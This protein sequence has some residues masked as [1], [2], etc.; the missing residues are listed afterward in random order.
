MASSSSSSKRHPVYHGIRRRGGKWVSE[1]R[2]P[3][4]TS[5]IWLGTF[6]TPEM[7]ATAYDVA[8]LALKGSEAVLN[9][10]D[11]AGKYPVPATNS[12]ADIRAAATAAAELIR[13]PAEEA[14]HNQSS[15]VTQLDNDGGNNNANSMFSETEFMDE[16][17]IFSM[18]SLLMEMAEGMLLS[19][20]RMSPHN[21]PEYSGGESLWNYF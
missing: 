4:K 18:P 3:R 2:E 17:T 7:A 16:E 5:R 14:G 6:L 10:P 15:N 13:S 8:A 9:F 19:P 11:S 21:S 1:I 12:A 20:P